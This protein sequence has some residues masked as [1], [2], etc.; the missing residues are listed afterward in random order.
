VRVYHIAHELDRANRAVL[1]LLRELGFTVAS[2]MAR[3]TPEEEAGLREAVER[4][5]RGAPAVRAAHSAA[6]SVQASQVAEVVVKLDLDIQT[7]GEAKD[8]RRPG[9]VPARPATAATVTRPAPKPTKPRKPAKGIGSAQRPALDKDELQEELIREA[10]REGI[11]MVS[12]A[13]ETFG[14]PAPAPGATGQP[15]G[16]LRTVDLSAVEEAPEPPPAMKRRAVVNVGGRQ[17]RTLRRM[18]QRGPKAPPV[19]AS[20]DLEIMVPITVKDFS[21]IVGVRAQDMIRHLMQAT[22]ELSFNMNTVLDEVQVSE[23]AGAFD[24]KVTVVSEKSAEEELEE[25]KVEHEK[26]AEGDLEPRPPVVTIL[27]HVDHGKTSLLDK[28]R[29]TNVAA[30]EFGGITQHIGAFQVETESGH[31]ISFLDTPGH[32]AFTAMRARG[33]QLADIVIL[34][35]AADDGVMPQTEEAINHA[36]LAE[37]PI[38]VAINKIDKPNANP[39][40]VKQQL[41]AH[42]LSPED[43]GGDTICVEVSALTGVGVDSLLESLALVAEVE[44]LKANP[45]APA[46]GHIVE[47]RKDPHRGVIATLLVE[48]GTLSRGD[49]VV[50]GMGIGRVRTMLD[51]NGKTLTKALPG[52]PVELFGL[53]DV[54]DA[55]DPFH[56]VADERL[57]RTAVDER[58]RV[59]REGAQFQRPQATLES[60]FKETAAEKSGKTLNIILKA[61][62]RGSLEPL[63]V[64]LG[65]LE[66]K[67]VKLEVLYA[68]LGAV[69]QSDVD[70]AIASNAVII[71]FHVLSESAAR[72]SAERAGVEIR[73]YNVIY[74]VVD[75]LKAALENLLAPEQ[76]ERITGHAEIRQIFPS[77]KFGN[78]AGSFVIDGYVR[79]ADYVRIYRDGK[80][81]YGADR[82]VQVDSLRRVKDDAKEV[83]EGF[84]CG[85]R[86]SAYQDVKQG[87]VIEFYEIKQ[88]K[89]TLES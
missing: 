87:D 9:A 86:I 71:G 54:P 60:L 51:S 37:V 32:A 41:T 81:M 70:A 23:L 66:H 42:A 65:K 68:T 52:T 25:S 11:E 67:E 80:L 14:P 17:I 38:V 89:R 13:D 2:H 46:A 33:A 24:R 53:D 27:G 85:I 88:L 28:I 47:A 63:K 43:W 57:A 44:E 74:E 78:I 20:Q 18:K 73:H 83:R 58:R 79:R 6:P 29:K 3:L 84:E 72:K 34:V 19:Q 7:N 45:K 10:E 12:V 4:Q 16:V 62:V 59:Q 36:K 15:E 56:V 31:K 8:G 30:G 21:Q 5:S 50:A 39:M 1:Q 55:G 69:T 26:A 40:K 82:P 22:G 48:D 49:Y 76:K 75:D 61:D 64:E 77:S 35:V